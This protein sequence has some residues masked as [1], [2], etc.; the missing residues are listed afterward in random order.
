MKKAQETVNILTTQFENMMGKGEQKEDKTEKRTGYEPETE[1]K[2]MNMK[3]KRNQR[4]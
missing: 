3:R 2:T 1:W 4:F